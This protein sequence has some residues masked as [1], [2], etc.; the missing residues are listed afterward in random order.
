[1]QV[2][3]AVWLMD[4]ELGKN[5]NWLSFK[6]HVDALDKNKKYTLNFCGTDLEHSLSLPDEEIDK[7]INML[8]SDFGHAPFDLGKAK[9]ILGKGKAYV[10]IRGKTDN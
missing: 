6:A 9:H 1:M 10:L 5:K 7:L 2:Q 4:V 3:I 8:C